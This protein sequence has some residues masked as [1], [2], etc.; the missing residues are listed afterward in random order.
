MFVFPALVN[1]ARMAH[2]PVPWHILLC[3]Q[4]RSDL[5]SLSGLLRDTGLDLSWDET[6]GTPLAGDARSHADLLLVAEGA[7]PEFSAQWE[8]HA[9]L[10]RAPMI[11][12][13]PDAMLRRRFGTPAIHVLDRQDLSASQL[14]WAIK[15]QVSGRRVTF[16]RSVKRR[17]EPAVAVTH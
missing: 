1:P 3:A 7:T 15:A 12:V 17:L 11:L 5:R 13:H 10:Q 14:A 4:N 16:P 6:G 9:L 2:A 8:R